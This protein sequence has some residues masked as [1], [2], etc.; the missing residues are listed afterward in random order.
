MAIFFFF[1]VQVEEIDITIITRLGCRP[2]LKI[3]WQQQV[4][5]PTITGYTIT[6][7]D[8]KQQD[9]EILVTK[10]IEPHVERNKY[11]EII[12]IPNLFKHSSVKVQVLT[13]RENGED[14]DG[15]TI[16]CEVKKGIELRSSQIVMSIL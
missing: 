14:T 12:P 8:G 1:A 10:T 4:V 2:A 15:R 3:T 11:C 16:D 5:D 7:R 9:N 13:R 6:I